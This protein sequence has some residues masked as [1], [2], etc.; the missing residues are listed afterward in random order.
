MTEKIYDY[1][2]IGS[3]FGGSVSA[4]RLTE[5]GYSVLVIEQGK[6]YRDPDFATT[7]WKVWKYIW[8]PALRCFG[9]LQI[10]ILKGVMILH[11]RGVGGGSLGY[12]NVLEVPSDEIFANPSWK[13]L[14]NWKEILHPHFETARHMLGVTRNP[15]QG[16]ADEVLREIAEIRGTVETFRATEVGVFFG[17]EG[18]EVSDPYFAGQGLPRTGCTFCGGCMIGCRY[19]AKNTLPKNY[20]YFAEKNGAEVLAE[21]EVVDVKHLPHD[22]SDEPRYEVYYHSSTAWPIKKQSAVKARNVIFSAGV[23]G[24]LKLLFKCRD[25]NGSLP[26]ISQKLGQLVRTNSEALM[27]V[28]HRDDQVNYSKGIAITS[29]VQADEVTRVE[30]VRYPDGSSLMRFISA[31]LIYAQGGVLKRL[32]LTAWAFFRHP[33]DSLRTHFLPGWARRGTILLV[34]QTTDNHMRMK[35]GRSGY[36]LFRR[37][38]VAEPDPEHTIPPRIDAAHDVT[39][40]FAR[41]TDGIPMGSLGENILNMPT[42]AHI[43]GGC[44]FGQD[45]SQGVIGLDCQIHNYPGLYVVDGSIMPANPGVNPSLTITALAEYA[46]SGIKPKK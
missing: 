29:I 20:L 33:I 27:G 37:G 44:S 10:S 16:K 23:L 14:A 46:M 24:T 9:I 41:K 3:G 15:Q 12:A 45:A 26:K 34:M 32:L 31:P 42:T 7:N 11:G 18:Q 6:R 25:L 36:T 39:W 17:S 43:L 40:A 1:I 5:K 35:F 38:L 19:N 4:M 22:N 13:H 21:N 8:L 30:P 2:I 28:I